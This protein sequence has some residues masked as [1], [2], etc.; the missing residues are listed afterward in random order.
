MLVTTWR[1]NSMARGAR[2]DAPPFPAAPT[3]KKTR[4]PTTTA[5]GYVWEASAQG[6]VAQQT[7][8]GWREG[9][10]PLP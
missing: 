6:A 4:P 10:P 1:R 7:A 9:S 2:G 8:D 3:R 5:V